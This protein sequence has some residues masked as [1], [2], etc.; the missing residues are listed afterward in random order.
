MI[1]FSVINPYLRLPN[2]TIPVSNV[3][4]AFDDWEEIV[5]DYLKNNGIENA[6]IFYEDATGKGIV[7]ST[8]EWKGN[9]LTIIFETYGARISQIP[10]GQYRKFEKQWKRLDSNSKTAEEIRR[11]LY[12]LCEMDKRRS[13][14][15]FYTPHRLGKLAW[16]R[17]VQHLGDQ[18]WSDGTWRIWDNCAGIGNLQYE[19]IPEDAMQYIYLS[20][21]GIAEVSAIQE[22][23]Y[24]KGKCR[25][26]FQFDWLNDYETKLP[27]SLRKDLQNKNIRWL[28]FIN[29]PYVD[30]ARGVGRKNDPGTNNTAIGNQMLER[31]MSESANE[32]TIQFLYR[33]ERD[34]GKR[35]YV[36]GLF[37]TAKWITKPNTEELRNYWKPN[38]CGGYVLNANEHFTEQKIVRN[39]KLS[40]VASGQFPILFSVLDRINK[41]LGYENQDWSY[42]VIDIN[43]KLTGDKKT[44]LPFDKD[45][46][47][48]R[49]YFFPQNKRS[50]DNT[51]RLPRMSGAVIPYTPQSGKERSDI[52]VD[53]RLASNCIGTMLSIPYDCQHINL[54]FLTTGSNSRIY[55]ITPDNYQSVLVGFALYKSLTYHWIYD[56]DIFY[57]PYRDLTQEEISDCL[58]FAL[59]HDSNTTAYTTVK[60]E[61]DTF[62][63]PNWFNPFDETK[64]DWSNLSTPGKQAL[65]KLTHYCENIVKWRTLQTPYGNN[66]GNGVWLGLYQ[67]RTAY[68]TVN[69]TYKKKFGKDYP[70]R[71]LYGIPYP[72][73]FREAIE[74]LRQRVEAL[75]IDLCLTAGKGERFPFSGVSR[76]LI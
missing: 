73:R 71:D 55:Q 37:S 12:D 13:T 25:G 8:R 39:E 42:E 17:I 7:L 3:I 5:R 63:L 33:I 20:D 76:G 34:F 30:A 68:E 32:L 67:Y 69:K 2:T 21:K 40:A 31:G 66:K 1:N 45:K 53:E 24:F 6:F 72:D 19:I 51:K 18:F 49:E 46:I 11:R 36:L 9:V 50:K 70:N 54:P 15:S 74:A 14:G 75:A 16:E 43:A 23:D 60:T 27:D 64:F 61:A 4:E 52:F 35:G 57:A 41:P 65:A 10:E 28:F 47:V 48:F 56:A 38:Y 22:N 58:L 59:L 26:I 29:P 44:F 62:I